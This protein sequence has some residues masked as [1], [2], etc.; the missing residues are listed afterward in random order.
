[1]FNKFNW[2]VYRYYL[3]CWRDG[4][5][6]DQNFSYVHLYRQAKRQ[7]SQPPTIATLTNTTK[8]THPNTPSPPDPPST[9]APT[10]IPPPTPCFNPSPTP[11]YAPPTPAPPAPAPPAPHPP[12]PPQPPLPQPSTIINPRDRVTFVNANDALRELRTNDNLHISITDK[13]AELVVMP[14]EDH[15][16]TTTTHFGNGNVYKKIDMPPD[17]LRTPK[18]IKKLTKTLED[19]VNSTFRRSAKVFLVYLLRRTIFS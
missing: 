19:E 9:T 8:P 12:R 17:Q 4:E 13:T 1:M 15:I 6:Y 2:L 18:Y 11:T 7:V 16:R 14:K 10:L 3:S 5:L